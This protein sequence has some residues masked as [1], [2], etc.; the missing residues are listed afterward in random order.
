MSFCDT[1]MVLPRR[2]LSGFT[3][4]STCHPRNPLFNKIGRVHAQMLRAASL[5][6]AKRY[7]PPKH[8]IGWVNR[9]N[10]SNIHNAMLFRL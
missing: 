1:K 9:E 8:P 5:T 7:K 6:I 4:P 10:R 2:E 3:T